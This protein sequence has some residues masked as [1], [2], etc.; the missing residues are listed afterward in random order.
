MLRRQRSKEIDLL[1]KVPL[2]SNLNKRQLNEISKH[3]NLLQVNDGYVMAEQGEKGGEFFFIVEGKAQVKKGSKIIRNL[4]NGDYF[5]EI[6]LID[7]KPRT[8]SVIAEND[9]TTLV[10]NKRSFDQLLKT[11]TGLEQN[12]L[13]TLCSYLRRAEI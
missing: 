7:G 13:V 8:A 6:S 10:I 2:F 9:T 11:V 5:G 1:K 3:A 12:I 4:K